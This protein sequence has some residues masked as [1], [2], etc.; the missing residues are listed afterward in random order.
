VPIEETAEFIHAVKRAS[1][2]IIG[3]PVIA[4]GDQEGGMEESLY[5]R[6]PVVLTTTQMGMGASGDPKDAYEAAALTAAQWKAI[7]MDMF[8]GPCV[9]VNSNPKNPEIAHRAFSDLP[10]VVATMGEQVIRAYKDNGVITTAKHFPGRGNSER[11]AHADL[12]VLDMPREHFDRIELAPYRRAIAAG[13][14]MVMCAHTIYPT[15]GDDKLPASFSPTIIQKV[16]RED[17]GFTGIV[18]PDDITM[19]GISNHWEIP[20]A[21]AMCIEA[22]CDMI[23]MKV[24]E[25]IPAAIKEIAGRVRSGRITE[26]RINESVER[27]MDL[28]SRYGLFDPPEFPKEKFQA[29]VGTSEQ[30]ET[31]ARLARRA[32]CALKNDGP[33]FP[34]DPGRYEKPLVIVP[35]DLTVVVANDPERSHDML[36]R[37]FRRYWPEALN[38]VIDRP[39]N[40]HQRYEVEGLVK[41]ADL[42]VYGLFAI[43]G[44]EGK[45]EGADP[46][47]EFLRFMADLGKPVAV[48]VTGAP[49]V[50]ETFYDD[51]PGIVCSWSINPL[52]FDAAVDLMAGKIPPHGRLPVEVSERLPRGFA[53]EIKPA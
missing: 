14:E 33:L 34:L 8:L 22:G 25:L 9:D 4:T 27:I 50:A 26:E 44:S 20:V 6:D 52:A 49:Y 13:V 31:G 28:K 5:R 35:R 16:L 32:V 12:D 24:N 23:L 3:V 51:V 37:S 18:Y 43:M 17:L 48:V 38:M 15:L 42:I 53:A 46:M 10:D 45:A 36:A 29:S 39:P 40:E 1:L 21:C 19:L 41:N 47:I 30:I 2:D 11:N 7:G